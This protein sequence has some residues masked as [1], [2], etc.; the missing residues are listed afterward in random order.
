MSTAFEGLDKGSIVTPRARSGNRP[1]T[2][3]LN[4]SA[5]SRV[6]Q[7]RGLSRVNPA[8]SNG[9]ALS[10]LPRFRVEA[11]VGA[12]IGGRAPGVVHYK[13]NAYGRPVEHVRWEKWAGEP[14]PDDG[15]GPYPY[16]Q[17][18]RMDQLFTATHI[19]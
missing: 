12:G 2:S 9:P 8:L 16:T 7:A 6:A 13:Y 15:I 19:A 10:T 14:Q 11:T 1:N 3:W 17:L 18:L 5:T 4:A